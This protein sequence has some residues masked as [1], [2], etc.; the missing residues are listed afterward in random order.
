MQIIAENRYF[1]EIFRLQNIRKWRIIR[2]KKTVSRI[3]RKPP[4]LK[5]LFKKTGKIE[6][7]G[8]SINSET[9]F[10]NSTRREKTWLQYDCGNKTMLSGDVNVRLN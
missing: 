1:S 2:D 9:G 8:L 4:F 3:T 5:N 7:T 10:D 6:K